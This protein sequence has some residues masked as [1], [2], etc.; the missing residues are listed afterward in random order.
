MGCVSLA[1]VTM[2]NFR[3]C[4]KYS[5]APLFGLI[6]EQRFLNLRTYG[7]FAGEPGALFLYGWLSRPAGLP[8]P[9]AMFRLP[10]NFARLTYDHASDPIRGCVTTHP[11]DGA[12]RYDARPVPG[13]AYGPCP[14]GSL[15]EFAM[16]RYSGFFVRKERAHVFRVWHPPWLQMPLTA[17]LEDTSLIV[18][19]FPWF[20][21]AKFVE[22]AVT[23]NVDQVRMG[24]AH[25][26]ASGSETQNGNHRVLSGFFDMP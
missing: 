20:E 12:F 22:A 5:P 6:R 4:R 3:A 23:A 9:S 10:Y 7:R 18:K 24:S 16:E 13:R 11:D 17:H 2:K 25:R 14:S 26:L 19:R 1:A 8:L 15:M 21:R